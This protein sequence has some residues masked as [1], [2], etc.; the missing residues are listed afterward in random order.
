MPEDKTIIKPLSEHM[1]A[2]L[3]VITDDPS[4]AIWIIVLVNVISVAGILC[5][6]LWQTKVFRALVI[7]QLLIIPLAAAIGFHYAIRPPA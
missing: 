3:S 4:G 2:L 6:P 5:S 1:Q 7:A